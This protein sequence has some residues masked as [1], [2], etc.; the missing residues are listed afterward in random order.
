MTPVRDQMPMTRP[1]R[2]PTSVLLLVALSAGGA[3]S[4]QQP[5]RADAPAAAEAKQPDVFQQLLQQEPR[6]EGAYGGRGLL[7]AIHGFL[8]LEYIDRENEPST[9]DL[10][11]AN[12]FVSGTISEQLEAYIEVEYEH[13]SETIELDQ[14]EI[15]YRP[16][17]EHD[18]TLGAGR[19]YAP[20]GIER[21]TWYPSIQ[22]LVSRP[23]A[24]TYVAP[25]NWYETGVRSD[26]RRSVGDFALR[27][28]LALSDGLGPDANTDIRASRQ[29]RDSNNNR[30]V[31]GRLGVSIPD[32]PTLGVSGASMKYD[33]DDRIGFLGF[34]AELTSGPLLLRGEWVSSQVEDP[35]GPVGDFSRC[36]YYALG[37]Y[38]LW[39]QD[40]RSFDLALRYEGIDGNDKIDDAMDADLYAI[41]LR[42]VPTE[43]LSL[44]FE[45]QHR[46][47]RH[48][49]DA[50]SGDSFF[51]QFVVDF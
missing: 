27:A 33:D 43:H 48:G 20:F 5:E 2:L 8:N 36:G 12:L 9:F 24:F 38:R 26:Y 28:E 22:P 39:E 50:A 23:Q 21:L 51:M 42:A 10:H 45:Y 40:G 1:S 7:V 19:F 15:R 11:H 46:E 37:S 44:K 25:G 49:L 4:A 17:A 14:A 6:S 13:A 29:F 3:A 34:D 30:A 41:G 32:G 47:A 31:T 16:L 35:T 18:L